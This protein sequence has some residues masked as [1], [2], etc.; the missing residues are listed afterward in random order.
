MSTTQSLVTASTGRFQVLGSKGDKSTLV[1]TKTPASS[2]KPKTITSK[3][4]SADILAVQPA[5]HQATLASDPAPLGLFLYHAAVPTEAAVAEM[6]DPKKAETK[7]EVKA[8]TVAPVAVIV[9]PPVVVSQ[10]KAMEVV[11]PVSKDPDAPEVKQEERKAPEPS[12]SAAVEIPPEDAPPKEPVKSTEK[13]P[14]VTD[15]DA[16]PVDPPAPKAEESVEAAAAPVPMAKETKSVEAPAA[17]VPMAKETKP[18]EAV[19]APVSKAEETKPAEEAAAAFA[20][21]PKVATRSISPP[22]AV[23]V[24]NSPTA[25]DPTV[26]PTADCGAC[27]I[28]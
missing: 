6:R 5:R 25:A 12:S 11:Q 23:A 15:A 13:V 14:V 2:A 7:P 16:K 21:A 9:A 24:S 1:V 17:S 27:A 8:A 28:L 22:A 3:P 4:F 10:P 20:P 26:V 18:V 19:A